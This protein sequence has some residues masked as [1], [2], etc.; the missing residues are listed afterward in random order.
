MTGSRIA[1]LPVMVACVAMAASVGLARQD[2]DDAPSGDVPPSGGA[3][4][5]GAATGSGAA[6]AAAALRTGFARAQSGQQDAL[7]RGAGLRGG[8]VSDDAAALIVRAL[9]AAQAFCAGMPQ[10]EYRVDCL[11]DQFYLIEQA[12]PARGDYAELRRSLR[13]VAEQLW[14]LARQ[15]A[16]PVLP[17]AVMRTPGGGRA[18][19]RALIPVRAGALRAVNRQASAVI[20]RAETVLLR[21][22]QAAQA[23]RVPFQRIAAAVGSTKVL[24]RSA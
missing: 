2:G 20:D 8:V 16:D 22:A 18:S 11:A 1:W 3:Y 24:L 5:Y 15:N 7:L 14:L 17:G 9:T 4:G 21:S 23:R 10:R 13:E 12:L 6:L 19:S